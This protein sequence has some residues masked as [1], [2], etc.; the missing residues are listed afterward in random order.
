[1][2]TTQA[3]PAALL[4]CRFGGLLLLLLLLLLL[5]VVVVSA[6]E[7]AAGSAALL[8][9]LAAAAATCVLQPLRPCMYA[10]HEWQS[11]CQL[12]GAMA[13]LCCTIRVGTCCCVRPRKLA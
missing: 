6:A 10:L 2:F 5:A 4:R 8:L 1:L 13:K 11:G 3:S 12:F 9:P 7:F